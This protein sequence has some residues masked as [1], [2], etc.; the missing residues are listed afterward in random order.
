MEIKAIDDLIAAE[1]S[2]LSAAGAQLPT[3]AVT[4][5]DIDR[6]QAIFRLERAA[7]HEFEFIVPR[8][9]RISVPKYLGK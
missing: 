9:E 6:Y 7:S 4:D 2:R 8:E 3:K 1:N 5:L